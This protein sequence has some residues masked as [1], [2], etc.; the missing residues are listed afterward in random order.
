VV[1][2]W[3]VDVN[4]RGGLD[5]HP[6]QLVVKDTAGGTGA[7]VTAVQEVIS[8]KVSA[9]FDLDFSDVQWVKLADQAGIPVIGEATVSQLLSP[10]VFPTVASASAAGY[11]LVKAAQTIGNKI[12]IAYAAE[13][14]AASQYSAQITSAAKALGA[15]VVASSKVS[16]SA[17]DYTAFCQLVKNSG[18]QEYVVVLSTAA[19]Q[20]LTDQCWQQGV[21]LPQVILGANSPRSWLSDPA[22]DGSVSVDT[23]APFFDESVPG[24]AEYR[25]AMQKYLPSLLGSPDDNSGGLG[26]WVIGKL[27]EFAVSAGKGTSPEA[28]LK[29]LYTAEDQTLDGA[30]P[31]LTFIQGK[32][33]QVNCEFVY[34]I[35][36]K[37]YALT[38][39]GANP[40]CA[41]ASLVAASDA[42]LAKSLGG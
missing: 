39:Q 31:P 4:S 10:T 42:Q 7:N 30:A 33:A 35:K 14:P 2:K 22:Y 25:A 24:V 19:A 6:V 23:L 11:V 29:G 5:G 32:H 36:N 17:P 41:P 15:S 40:L 18:A 9:I 26:G 13:V 27:L 38:A 16:L 1:E 21:H 12:A 37:N 28:I 20:K 34:T 8:Q 3:A